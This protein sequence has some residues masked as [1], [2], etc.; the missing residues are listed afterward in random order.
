MPRIERD[1]LGEVEVPDGALWGA[2][3]QRSHDNFPISGR[4]PRPELLAAG[5]QVKRA[6]ALAHARTGRMPEA[7]AQAIAWACEEV[8]AGRHLDQFIVDVYQAGAGTS[9][10]MNL[11]EVLANLASIHRGGQAGDHRISAH[12][13][14]NMGQSTNDIY[15]TV[16][17]VAAATLWQETRQAVLDLGQAFS[18]LAR[19]T[20]GVLKTGR[21]HLQDAVPIRYGQEFSGYAATLRQAVAQADAALAFLYELNIGATANGT[22]LNAEPGYPEA[23]A[24]ELEVA[25]GLPFRPPG[26]RF[27]VTQSLADFTFFSAGLEVLATELSRIASDLR[28]LSS[29]PHAGIG[30]L[31]LPEVQ[32]GS[33][34]MPGKVN[35]SIPEMVNMVALDVV[36]GHRTIAGAAQMGQ[37]ELNVMMPIVG[38]RLVESLIILRGACT[39][40]RTRCVEGIEVDAERS[41]RLLEGSGA[42]ATALS[43]HVGYAVAAELQLEANR[44]GRSVR[45]LVVERGLLTPAQADQALDL[46]RMT[47]PGITG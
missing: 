23:A 32:P 1:A 41:L 2:H 15:P 40:L 5:A 36:G 34:I 42:L 20:D 45:D 37:L 46:M 26:N 3:A 9:F 28:L 33:S 10:N 22:G 24:R 7:T 8:I 31:R 4:L 30:E 14:V 12:D 11:N 21:T 44:S 13:D 17:R 43:P 16:L 27:R 38:Y 19:R 39:A 29:G 6:A 18:D 25:L 35:P 47:E